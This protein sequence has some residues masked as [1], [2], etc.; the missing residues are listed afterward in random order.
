[1]SSN[2]PNIQYSLSK[3]SLSFSMMKVNYALNHHWCETSLLPQAV[4]NYV[5]SRDSIVKK[6]VQLRDQFCTLTRMKK[7]VWHCVISNFFYIIVITLCII[8]ACWSQ[9][10]GSYVC[11]NDNWIDQWVSKCDPLSTLDL[12]LILAWE[13][14]RLSW[15][16]IYKIACCYSKDSQNLE[17]FCIIVVHYRLYTLYY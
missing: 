7:S 9:V 1:M 12:T 5:M 13:F 3:W 15:F 14:I 10:H 11:H 4:L 17:V 2:F 8:S 6:S 16:F